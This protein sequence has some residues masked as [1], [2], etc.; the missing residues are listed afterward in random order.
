MRLAA[1]NAKSKRLGGPFA[2]Y[3]I[4]RSSP[5]WF[6]ISFVGSQAG[7]GPALL[8]KYMATVKKDGRKIVN[9]RTISMRTPS[10]YRRP[11]Q[12]PRNPNS[13][14][15][16]NFERC[17]YIHVYLC[18][19]VHIQARNQENETTQRAFVERSLPSSCFFTLLPFMFCLPS[20]FRC[21]TSSKLVRGAIVECV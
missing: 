1:C 8:C 4:A 19:P 3:V 14:G 20:F 13:N 9:T 5:T 7:L 6:R 12:S 16:V 11:S 17:L 18:E 15:V 10:T 21:T 2:Q